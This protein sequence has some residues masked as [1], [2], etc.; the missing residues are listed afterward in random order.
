MGLGIVR[1]R[2]LALPEGVTRPPGL[3]FWQDPLADR[4]A[5][6]VF[7]WIAGGRPLQPWWLP[8]WWFTVVAADVDDARG[9]AALWLVRRPGSA[10]RAVS[11]QQLLERRADGTWRW[12]GGGSVRPV[13]PLPSAA[14]RLAAGEPGHL[15][16]AEVYAGAGTRSMAYRLEHGRELVGQAPWIGCTALQ[17]AAEVAFVGL[18]GRRILVPDTGTMIVVW[19]VPPPVGLPGQPPLTLAS[20]DGT[21]LSTTSPLHGVDSY[22]LSQLPD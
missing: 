8:R 7:R 4:I 22:T 15:G 17:V 14:R 10:R 19:Q 6:R 9:V 16:M 18:G 13:D 12:V 3:R 1:R 5:M 21:V 20:A 2:R 11:F